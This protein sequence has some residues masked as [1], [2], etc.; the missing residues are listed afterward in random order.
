L[1][2]IGIDPGSNVTGYGLVEHREGKLVH[3]A[4]GTLRPQR[5]A[6]LSV[7]LEHLHRTLAEILADHRPDVAAVEQVFVSASPKAAL[8]LGQ[9]RGVALAALGAAGLSV[10][11]YSPSQVKL[12]VTGSGRAPKSQVKNMVR[13]M[14]ALER[15]PAEDAADALAV[16]IRHASGGRLED[17]GVVPRRRR[18][19][20]RR[21]GVAINVRPQR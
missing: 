18:S 11:E 16:A 10:A 6:A 17:A 20:S 13:R 1:R 21:S 9:A 2:I 7:R 5:G 19:S 14:L 8:V 15:T 4:H 12:A 3:I